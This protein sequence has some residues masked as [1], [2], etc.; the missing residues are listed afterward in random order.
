[1][2]GQ[3]RT[4][5]LALGSNL[6][7]RMAY[8]TEAVTALRRVPGLRVEAVSPVYQ[9]APVG[10][11]GHPAYLNAV[12]LV[13]TSLDPRGLIA[14][15]QAV[16]DAYGRVRVEKWGPRTLDIDVLAVGEEVSEDPVVLLPHP[17]AHTRAFVLVPWADVAPETYVPGRGRVVD[18]LAALPVDEVAEVRRGLV[19]A[20]AEGRVS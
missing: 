11:S 17:L 16:E 7:D 1:M 5:A 18:L 9:T 13:T 15:T 4:A 12:V 8:L 10:T 20:L 19:G 6:G 14:A 2:T 3:E